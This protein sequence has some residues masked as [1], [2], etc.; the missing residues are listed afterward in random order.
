[1]KNRNPI[2]AW[3]L[4]ETWFEFIQIWTKTKIT[5]WLAQDYI[6]FDSETLHLLWGH[7]AENDVQVL[8]K[9]GVKMLLKYCLIDV[10][11]LLKI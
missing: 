8:L 11:I 4:I 2:G 7:V 1:M 5:I 3:I 10:E 6:E 9:C